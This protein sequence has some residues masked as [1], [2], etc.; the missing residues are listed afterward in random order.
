MLF[1]RLYIR[2][3]PFFPAQLHGINA[4][5]SFIGV[6]DADQAAKNRWGGVIIGYFLLA[7]PFWQTANSGLLLHRNNKASFRL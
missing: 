6:Q 2:M 3:Q 4:R 1:D 7:N 5:E